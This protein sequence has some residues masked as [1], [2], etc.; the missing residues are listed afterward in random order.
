MSNRARDRWCKRADTLERSLP[1][2][3][4]LLPARGDDVILLAGTGRELWGLLTE[5][6]STDELTA[7]LARRYA[8]DASNIRADIEAVLTELERDGVVGEEA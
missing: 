5:P 7:E 3:V 2:G 8:G 6:R 1:S 4:L